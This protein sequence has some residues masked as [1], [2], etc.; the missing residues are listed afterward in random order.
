MKSSYSSMGNSGDLYVTF[1]FCQIRQK[2][3]NTFNF[4]A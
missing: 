4:Y 2:N 3:V 1:L